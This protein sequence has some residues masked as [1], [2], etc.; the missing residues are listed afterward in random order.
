[1]TFNAIT[2]ID[3]DAP[4]PALLAYWASP[5]F[6]TYL[7]AKQAWK[8]AH[9]TYERTVINGDDKAQLRSYVVLCADEA[10]RTLAICRALPIHV[11]AFGW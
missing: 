9:D 8:E 5:E 10:R 2:P 3:T 6:K 4:S 7:D 11:E 1:M